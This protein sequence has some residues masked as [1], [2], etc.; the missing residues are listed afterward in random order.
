M[1]ALENER[2]KLSTENLGVRNSIYTNNEIIRKQHVRLQTIDRK[3]R[4]LESMLQNANKDSNY[5]KIIEIVVQR[6][7]DKRS[8]LVAALIAVINTLKANPYGFNL[9]SS[10]SLDI[11]DY[12]TNDVD[13]KNLLQFAE[14]CYNLLLKSFVKNIA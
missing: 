14:S 11:E 1:K 9:M 13:G 7:N 3:R 8:L 10:S 4:A 12:I 2:T 6:L 5:H